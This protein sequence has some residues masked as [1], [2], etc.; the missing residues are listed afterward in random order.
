MGGVLGGGGEA[1]ILNLAT[2]A[3][4]L[5]IAFATIA[6]IYWGRDSDNVDRGIAL[7]AMIMLAVMGLM[8]A[9]F[10]VVMP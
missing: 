5:A 9:V 1:V 4:C 10:I 8:L 2:L 6:P 7:A 3:V